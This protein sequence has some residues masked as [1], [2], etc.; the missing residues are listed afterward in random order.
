[1]LHSS[2]ADVMDSVP[3]E[4]TDDAPN[5]ALLHRLPSLVSALPPASRVVIQMHYVDGLR[6]IEIAEALEISLGTV[7]SRLAYGLSLLRRMAAEP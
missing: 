5:D 4:T 2:D 7:K 6:L 1:M 3:A